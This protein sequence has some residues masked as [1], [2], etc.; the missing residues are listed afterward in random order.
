[1]I[2]SVSDYS[3]WIN[4]MVK[5][6]YKGLDSIKHLFFFKNLALICIVDG[7]Q[8]CGRILATYLAKVSHLIYAAM[9]ELNILSKKQLEKDI[10][11]FFIINFVKDMQGCTEGWHI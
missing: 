7:M 11:R 4:Y 3:D 9:T 8:L 5:N 10:A 6:N 1:M 2:R